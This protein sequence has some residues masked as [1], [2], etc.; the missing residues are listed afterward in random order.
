MALLRGTDQI[1]SSGSYIVAIEEPESHLHPDAIHKLREILEEISQD[2]Q[3]IVT[4]HSPYLVDRTRLSRTLLVRNSTAGPTRS[5]R[6]VRETL[7]A[8]G[9]S[10]RSLVS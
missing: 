10:R 5:I 9:E 2:H 7:A 6:E 3:V 8:R 1:T 4:S